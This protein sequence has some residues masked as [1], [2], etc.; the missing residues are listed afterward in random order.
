ME[1]TFPSHQRKSELHG[2]TVVVETHGG[3]LYV[4]RC[5]DV[6]SDGVILLD[7]DTHPAAS[8]EVSR[9]EFL[10]RAARFG[11]WPRNPR[12]IIPREDVASLKLLAEF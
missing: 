7:A 9:T 4:G 6:V 3:D 8:E 11:V 12:L 5:Y 1:R 10:D 2:L